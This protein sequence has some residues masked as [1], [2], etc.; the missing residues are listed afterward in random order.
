MERLTK[1]DQERLQRILGQLSGYQAAVDALRQQIS[2]LATSLTELSMTVGAIKNLKELKPDTEILVPI[3]SDS[4]ITAKLALS[5]KVI[6]GLGADVSVER[7]A[8]DAIQVLEARGKEIEEAI[9]RSRE[10]LGRLEERIETLRPEAERIL[11]KTRE[12]PSGRGAADV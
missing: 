8:D 10:E 12:E 6:T 7:K 4:F 3:G 5:D 2:I 1:E 9:E 11:Q